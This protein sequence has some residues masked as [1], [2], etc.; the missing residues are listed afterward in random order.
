MKIKLVSLKNLI[1]KIQHFSTVPIAAYFA[2]FFRY[3]T[4]FTMIILVCFALDHILE[5]L[6]IIYRWFTQLI[7]LADRRGLAAEKWRTHSPS[8]QP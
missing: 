3:T 5:Y 8:F 7:R 2:I 6:F 4:F 1:F